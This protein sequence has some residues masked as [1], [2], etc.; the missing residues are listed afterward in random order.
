MAAVLAGGEGAV[1]SHRSAAH[2]HGLLTRSP[3]FADVTAPRSGGRLQGLQ[4]HRTRRLEGRDVTTRRGIPVTTVQR[5]VT[6]LAEVA[7]RRTVER[8]AG[9][10]EI[11]YGITPT[12][13][14]G[15]R[16]AKRLKAPPDR[17]RSELE[18]AFKRLC[19][20][21]GLPRPEHNARVHGLEVDFLWREQRLVVEL[22]GWRYHR[23][24]RAFED[25]RAR[26]QA[27]VRAGFAVLRFTHRQATEAPVRVAATVRAALRGPAPLR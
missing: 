5:T 19:E 15:R 26:D 7:D 10:A 9:Q 20:E 13:I 11:A 23:S 25:D 6:D 27:L 17:S 22:D 12:P 8:A 3:A 21:R 14:D 2:L 16:G 1:L 4:R 24:R 18:R